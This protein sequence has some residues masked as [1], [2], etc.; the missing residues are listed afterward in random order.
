MSK[1]TRLKI[2]QWRN[3]EKQRVGFTYWL[4][5]G[6][7][8]EIEAFFCE[9]KAESVDWQFGFFFPPWEKD[10]TCYQVQSSFQRNKLQQ[11]CEGYLIHPPASSTS[12]HPSPLL[13][14]LRQL[15]L[16]SPGMARLQYLQV[17]GKVS[18]LAFLS[19]KPVNLN[20]WAQPGAPAADA[21]SDPARNIQ[22]T[23]AASPSHLINLDVGAGGC[24]GVLGAFNSPGEMLGKNNLGYGRH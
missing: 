13:P 21:S 20:R 24:G 6:K 22:V 10:V 14:L 23:R 8:N 16:L 7:K 4:L 15:I 3:V 2:G 12:P 18:V 17:Q 1:A 9:L 19:F 11:S 5:L